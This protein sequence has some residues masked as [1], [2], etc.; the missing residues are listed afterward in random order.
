MCGTS[1]IPLVLLIFV[2]LKPGISHQSLN[3]KG[4]FF[5]PCEIDLQALGQLSA[6]NHLGSLRFPLFKKMIQK[7]RPRPRQQPPT[8]EQTN[9]DRS[10]AQTD[11]QNNFSLTPMA[12]GAMVVRSQNH[13]KFLQ[14]N[15][16]AVRWPLHLSIAIDQHI[17]PTPQPLPGIF[18][19][20]VHPRTRTPIPSFRVSSVAPATSTGGSDRS[21]GV[22]T[23]CHI[24]V[25]SGRYVLLGLGVD[26][27]CWT[28]LSTARVD[29]EPFLSRSRPDQDSW[30]T[31]PR[32]FRLLTPAPHHRAAFPKWSF[33]VLKYLPVYVH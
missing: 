10:R 33:L 15:I 12:G 24:P 19:Q 1:G 23:V 21:C 32:G 17:N 7:S 8:N 20:P 6:S 5:S 9:P 28:D 22:S 27:Q 16:L 13:R 29:P 11:A 30:I 4:T 31:P 18:E 25:R 26:P 14:F 3:R 2:G